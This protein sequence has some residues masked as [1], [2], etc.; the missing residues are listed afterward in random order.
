MKTKKSPTSLCAAAFAAA[1]FAAGPAAATIVAPSYVAAN[2]TPDTFSTASPAQLVNNSGMVVPVV[3]G[4]SLND[5]LAANHIFNG[6]FAE[7]WV[8]NDPAPSGGDYFAQSPVV[9]V[10]VFD[11]GQD[12]SVLDLFFWQYQNNG[13]GGANIGNQ[14]KDIE[15]RFNTAAEGSSSF[16]GPVFNVNNLLSSLS[17]SQINIGQRRTLPAP[18][19]ARYVQLRVTDNYFGQPGITGGGDRVGIGEFRVNVAAD[20]EIVLPG[21][22]NASGNGSA[23][24]VL[25]P[26]SNAGSTLPLDVTNLQV[27]GTN[28]G[29]FTIDTATPFTLAP[30]ASGNISLTI[31]PGGTLGPIAASLTITSNDLFASPNTVPITGTIREPWI[32]TPASATAG[33]LTSNTAVQFTVPVTNLGGIDNLEIVGAFPTGADAAAVA[34]VTDFTTPLVIA[35]GATTDVTFSFDPAGEYRTF[36]ATLEFD[37]NDSGEP[38]RVIPFTAE[39]ARDPRISGPALVS[40]GP[41]AIDAAPLSIPVEITNLGTTNTLNLTTVALDGD[42]AF[43]IDSFP[44]TIG[45][46][47][48]GTINLTFT[49]DGTRFGAFTT[50]LQLD[51][52]DPGAAFLDIPVTIEVLPPVRPG[53]LVAWYPMDNPADPG[54]D[55]SGNNLHGAAGGTG[56]LTAVAGAATGTGGA[57]D[58]D[59][60]SRITI[61]QHPALNSP[62]FTVTGW[63]KADSPAGIQ[64]FITSRYDQNA[65]SSNTY[66][67][68]LYVIN[69]QW[70]FWHGTAPFGDIWSVDVTNPPPGGVWQHLAI[71]YDAGTNTKKIHVNGV[72]VSSTNPAQ[73]PQRNLVR[74]THIGAGQ[75]LGDGFFFNGEIDDVAIFSTA[76]STTDINTLYTSGVAGFLGLVTDAYGDWE[77]ANGIQGA[78]SAVDSDGDGLANGIEFVVGGDP[79]GPGSD[80]SDKLPTVALDATYLNFTFRRTDASA[81]YSPFV[82]YGSDLTGWTTAEAGVNGVVVEETDAFF[83]TGV[84]RVIVRIPRALATSTKL[85]ARLG[86]STD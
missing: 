75:D 13:G 26:V 52:N 36:S 4:T 64:S 40:A 73:P 74:D 67:Y 84:D 57:L 14:V 86:I 38:T 55:A 71:S 37:S 48:S 30:G 23:R 69:N 66:G 39:L 24:T 51:T 43:A 10:L 11:L 27:N 44:A 34:V 20:P 33:V 21:T 1:L 2:S 50:T 47:S 58:F 61:P 85:F 42:A 77:S 29:L 15:V 76:L 17:T 19:T 9:P 72:E 78:G 82:E 18:T 22:V 25:V 46:E 12:L 56:T 6:G 32:S 31:T 3:S 5:A 81:A 41:V 59:G 68:I 65:I 35:P 60:A 53:G 28:A 62:S 80:D 49:P 8:T 16:T 70:E 63:A 79:S 7:S 83:G 54:N 45:A